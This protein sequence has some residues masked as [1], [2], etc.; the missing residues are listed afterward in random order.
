MNMYIVRKYIVVGFRLQRYDIISKA[1]SVTYGK[2]AKETKTKTIA[3]QLV[4]DN[5]TLCLM[6]KILVG[7]KKTAI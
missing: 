1:T 6:E 7:Y 5:S 2:Y 4:I 3:N